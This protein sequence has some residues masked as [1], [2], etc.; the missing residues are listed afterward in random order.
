MRYTL[1]VFLCLITLIAY[2]QR[3]A[4]NGATKAV[5]DDLHTSSQNLGLVMGG[6][7]L[8][9][10][11]LQ[12][13]G[14]WAADRLGSKPALVLFAVLWSTMTGLAG[15]A[16][17]PLGLL[18]LWAAMGGAQAGIFPCCTKAIGATFPK[19]QQAFAS[20]ALACCMS[21]GAALAPVITGQ[22]LGPLTWR[23]I[24]AVY[25]VPGLAWAV[26]F[27]LVVRRP[28]GPQPAPAPESEERTDGWHALPPKA[29]ARVRWSK[30]VTDR[31]MLLLCFQQFLRAGAMVFFY[32]WFARFLQETKGLTTRDAGELAFWPPF[33]GAFGGLFGGLLS[34]W[35]LRR[36]GNARLA[37]QGMTF[38]AL[39]TCTGVA[40]AAYFVTDPH[41][42]VLLISVGTFC[43]MASGVSAYALAIAYGGRHV[44]TVFATMNMSGNL[45]ATAFPVAVASI[46]TATGNW[47][48]ALLLFVSLFGTA[49]VC[50]VVLNPKGTLFDTEA[51]K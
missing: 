44:A 12:L 21:L 17:G 37:R 15:L 4:M 23:H 19:T 7:Y 50:W 49:A 35:V 41:V 36:T 5:E 3:S 28:N 38:V 39:V 9:Y 6:W 33:A 51:L 40:A 13:P 22:L 8:L 47:N 2:V 25:A 27:G 32:T 48:Y 14:G 20:G 11:L 29:E 42:A 16:A 1:L 34:D 31:Q 26:L 18:L 30:L 24:F 45:G 46:V 10:S 43:G